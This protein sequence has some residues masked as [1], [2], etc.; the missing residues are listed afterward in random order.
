MV[1]QSYMSDSAECERVEALED[2]VVEDYLDGRLTPAEKLAFETHFLN[3][4]GRREKLAFARS[5]RKQILSP[6]QAMAVEAASSRW[7][8]WSVPA[9]RF[10]WMQWAAAASVALVIVAVGSL[11]VQ[12]RNAPPAIPPDKQAATTEKPMLPEKSPQS[13]VLH[14]PEIPAVV[15]VALSPGLTRS[16]GRSLRVSIP[17]GADIVEFKLELF[18]RDQKPLRAVLRRAEGEEL[19]FQENLR[20]TSRGQLSFLVPA[21]LLR[22]GDYQISLSTRSTDG[23][24]EPTGSY[25]FRLVR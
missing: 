14:S 11:W 1:E 13:P 8:A 5:L 2:E 18:T 12:N 23:T 22:P 7:P 4:P 17:P 20:P 3:G 19:L 15:H 9:V 10:R 6:A 21:A 16:T 25:Y 24:Y